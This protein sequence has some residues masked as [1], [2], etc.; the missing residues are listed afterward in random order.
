M[1]TVV[2]YFFDK[3]LVA[4]ILLH[5][6]D[7]LVHSNRLKQSLSLLDILWA[8]NA[9]KNA[10]QVNAQTSNARATCSSPVTRVITLVLL[11]AY[12]SRS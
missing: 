2:R 3:N 9:K 5:V 7:V 11:D 4:N 1:K 6:S 10:K 8:M 12:M